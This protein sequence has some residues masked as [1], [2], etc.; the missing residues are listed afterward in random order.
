VGGQGV[1]GWDAAI[2]PA[3]PTTPPP[4]RQAGGIFRNRKRRRGPLCPQPVS[5]ALPSGQSPT[6]RACAPT[7]APQR[8][9]W[10]SPAAELVLVR[11]P[12][13]NRELKNR[14]PRAFCPAPGGWRACPAQPSHCLST[15]LLAHTG[16]S[17]RLWA[18][19]CL[20]M[21][22]RFLPPTTV[23]SGYL[24]FPFPSLL[25]CCHWA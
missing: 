25:H 21:P 18:G 13:A 23:H 7:S 2:A 16:G 6:A 14:E 12:N 8:L 19:Y 15:L 11:E 1:R 20:T 10:P 17:N 24:A 4:P 9:A 3:R 22:A 5:R